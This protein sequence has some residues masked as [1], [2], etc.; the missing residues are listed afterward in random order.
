M[1]LDSW[2]PVSTVNKAPT[3]PGLYRFVSQSGRTLYVGKADGARGLLGRIN[4]NKHEAMKYLWHQKASYSIFVCPTE[5]GGATLVRA[6]EQLQ[7]ELRPDWMYGGL[8]ERWVK[9]KN[10]LASDDQLAL[11]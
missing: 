4:A 3:L 6:E 11:F 5:Y 1:P 7:A 8:Q 10:A 2:L 9:I